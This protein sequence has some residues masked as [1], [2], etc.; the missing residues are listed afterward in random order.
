MSLGHTNPSIVKGFAS[1]AS[2]AIARGAVGEAFPWSSRD[3]IA[4][5]SNT[6]G[7]I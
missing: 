2:N 5:H 7:A 1:L 6:E 4:T 3:L